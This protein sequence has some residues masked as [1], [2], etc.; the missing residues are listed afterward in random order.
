MGEL[1]LNINPQ[2]LTIFQLSLFLICL[3]AHNSLYLFSNFSNQHLLLSELLTPFQLQVSMRNLDLYSF[4]FPS[5]HASIWTLYFYRGLI[6]IALYLCNLFSWP[7]SLPIWIFYFYIKPTEYN[8][9]IRVQLSLPT[10]ILLYLEFLLLSPN[11]DNGFNYTNVA[12]FINQ[13]LPLHESCILF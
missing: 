13:H 7:T 12:S 4:S 1:R 6:T 11:Y 10:N 2:E 5:T 9:F 8:S 3:T